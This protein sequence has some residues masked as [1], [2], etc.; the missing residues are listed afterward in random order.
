[1]LYYIHVFEQAYWGW[2]ARVPNRF[3][4][5]EFQNEFGS[6]KDFS[7]NRCCFPAPSLFFRDN[8]SE[9]QNSSDPHDCHSLQNIL[10]RMIVLIRVI[11]I[12]SRT[13]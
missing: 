2:T 3:G 7:V 4:H 1:M 8:R 11:I 6:E 10:I 13:F 9:I 12:A 5:Y